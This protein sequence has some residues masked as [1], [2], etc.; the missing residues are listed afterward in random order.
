ME[1]VRLTTGDT[2]L[3]RKPM[4]QRKDRDII[5]FYVR[6]FELPTKEIRIIGGIADKKVIIFTVIKHKNYCCF[7]RG[8][9]CF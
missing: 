6:E 9:L 2:Q 7:L 4:N 5:P 8:R 1:E 3:K